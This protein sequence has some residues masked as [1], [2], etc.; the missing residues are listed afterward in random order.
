MEL[1]DR[2]QEHIKRMDI[3]V[4]ATETKWGIFLPLHLVPVPLKEAFDRQWSKLS[5]AILES[6]HE[7]VM[8]LADGVIR[9]LWKIDDT[10]N[11]A[12]VEPADLNPIGVVSEVSHK[13]EEDTK[14][15]QALPKSFFD[16]GGDEIPF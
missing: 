10:L 7:D 1:Q 9:G 3:V 13:L 5:Q 12:G 14:M 4:R 11:R 16:N 8:I 2:A 6:R 15:I